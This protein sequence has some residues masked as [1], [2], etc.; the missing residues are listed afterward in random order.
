MMK[1]F[2]NP[3]R[4][5]ASLALEVN[6]NQLT[7][8]G[9]V[10]DFSSLPLD[11]VL[12]AAALSSPFFTGEVF[13]LNGVLQV[14]VLLPHGDSPEPDVAF[15]VPV[16]LAEGVV[17]VPGHA[18]WAGDA[19]VGVIDWAAVKLPKVPSQEEVLQGYISALDAHMDAQARTRRYD[20]RVTCSLRA[21]YPG[22]FQAEGLAFATWM[23][24]CN[25]FG[26]QVLA[27]VQAGQRPTPT[28][29]EFIQMLPAL[30]WPE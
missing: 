9:E 28:I 6:G 19:S 17:A 23:D 24:A 15:P 13:W 14:S 7:V 10:F 3:Q 27:E 18:E 5:E 12:P 29:E 1:I 25:A 26:Y 22:P 21:G 16:E 11:G 30:V 2:F 8:N 4:S 20:N